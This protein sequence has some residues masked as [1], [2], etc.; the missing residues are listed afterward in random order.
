[1][2][3]VTGNEPF[4]EQAEFYASLKI[5]EEMFQSSILEE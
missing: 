4:D 2:I 5:K 3:E 1:M